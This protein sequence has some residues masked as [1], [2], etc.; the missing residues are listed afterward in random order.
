MTD[1]QKK[2]LDILKWFD[3]FC[4]EN[5]LSYYLIGG[6]MLGAVRHSGFI[7]WD[8]DI[9]VGMPRKDY[10]KL[11][12]LLK[13]TKGK[14]ILETP[15]S[16]NDDY[17]YPICKIYDTSTTLIEKKRKNVKRGLFID[18]FP[19]DGLGNTKEESIKNYAKIN[20]KYDKLL[21]AVA[22]IR[23]GRSFIKNTAVAFAMV[24]GKL[25]LNHKKLLKDIDKLCMQY[26]FDSYLW[27]G[28]LL[29]AWRFKEI[30]PTELFGKPTNILFEGIEVSGV[31]KPDEY[32]SYIYGDWR[33]L[34]P[35]EK[36]VSHH[37]FV[38]L[39]LEKSYLENKK[40]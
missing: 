14:Y 11:Q 24:F 2:L 35:I 10:M 32:L 7:P 38:C 22:G 17:Y 8:D 33:K 15:N 19:L 21:L 13:D 34:P 4:E 12:E 18:V 37:D 28:N 16:E 39:D 6:T 1:L 27:G 30:I 3:A 9:D 23:K 25:F 5:D 29:G 40:D 20:R 31:E 26:D 36:Q